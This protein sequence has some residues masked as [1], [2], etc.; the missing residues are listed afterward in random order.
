[1]LDA[2]LEVN[3]LI[4]QYE[5]Q[6]D[7]HNKIDNYCEK[8]SIINEAIEICTDIVRHLLVYPHANRSVRDKIQFAYELRK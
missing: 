5:I 7:D 8:N 3:S 1:M 6:Y 4:D 2:L